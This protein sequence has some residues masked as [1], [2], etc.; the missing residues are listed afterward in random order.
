MQHCQ[1]I[2]NKVHMLLGSLPMGPAA[3][4]GVNGLN[5]FIKMDAV[6][7]RKGTFL[8]VSSGGLSGNPHGSSNIRCLTLLGCRIA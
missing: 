7:K 1:T 3:L 8:L 6:R 2:A 5:R 4:S